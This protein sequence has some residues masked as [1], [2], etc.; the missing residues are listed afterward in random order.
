MPVVAVK[1]AV[2][3]ELTDMTFAVKVALIAVG[4]T[5]IDPGITTELLLLVSATVTPAVG[6][7][8]VSDTLQVSLRA[9]VIDVVL[10]VIELTIG[11]P[12]V[13]VPLRLTETAGALLWIVSCPVADA[14]LVGLN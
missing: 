13:P 3:A 1:F 14:V 7:E 9:P 6:A 10:Q 5:V 4:G 12:D 8:P 2:C 11:V